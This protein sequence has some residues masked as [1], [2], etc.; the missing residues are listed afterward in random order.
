MSSHISNVVLKISFLNKINDES[1]NRVKYSGWGGLWR[2]LLMLL[3]I[4]CLSL[5]TFFHQ[6]D[7]LTTSWRGGED[8][9]EATF[10]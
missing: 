1:E 5:I 2:M 3:L 7:I 8:W 6:S 4:I 10:S 9:W